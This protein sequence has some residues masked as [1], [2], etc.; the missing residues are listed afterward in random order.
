MNDLLIRCFE[1]RDSADL[2]GLWERCGLVRAW[3]DPAKDIRRKLQVQPHLFLVGLVDGAIVASVMAGYDG[4]RGWINYLA[5]DPVHHRRGYGT[6][7]MDQAE[8]LLRSEGCP[9]INVQVRA[10]NNEVIDFYKNL[11]YELETV[12]NMGKRLVSDE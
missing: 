4:H 1:E 2:I 3:N 6:Q 12:L 5:V 9:K 8:Q 11:D 7:L 10:E